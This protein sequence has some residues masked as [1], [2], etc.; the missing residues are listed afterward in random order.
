MKPFVPHPDS[1]HDVAIVELTPP[2]PPPQLDLFE[3]T[4]N[5]ST[6]EAQSTRGGDDDAKVIRRRDC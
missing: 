3:R 2:P 4:C 1:W 5:Q 6:G